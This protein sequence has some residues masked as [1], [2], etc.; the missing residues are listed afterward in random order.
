VFGSLYQSR[1]ARFCGVFVS[2]YQLR[3]APKLKNN[4]KVQSFAQRPL[5]KTKKVIGSSYP[6]CRSWTR[7]LVM[8]SRGAPSVVVAGRR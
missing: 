8:A 2:P 7:S 4:K 5:N 3:L 6:P 1:E